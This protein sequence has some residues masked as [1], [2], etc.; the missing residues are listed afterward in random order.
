MVADVHRTLLKGGIFM[1]PEDKKSVNGKLRLLYECNPMSFIIEKAGGK[2]TNGK[3]S[4]LEVEPKN[5]HQR[6]PIYI[7]SEEDINDYLKFVEENKE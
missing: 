4:I 5:I 1:Y 7:G 2:S 6:I 3:I